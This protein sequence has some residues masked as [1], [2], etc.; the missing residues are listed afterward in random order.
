MQ[1]LV[2]Q[3]AA[4]P[5]DEGRSPFSRAGG[6]TKV[7]EKIFADGVTLRSDPAEPL[8]P[9][10]PFADDGLP[11]RPTTWAENGVLKKLWRSRYWAA[12][13]NAEP[14][15]RPRGL[16]LG[17]GSS[18][19]DELVAG[20]KRGLLVTRFWYIRMVDPQQLLLT[21]LTRDG[22]FLIEDGKVVAPV[23][24]FR[25]NESPIALLR[26][27]DG[28]G[29]VRAQRGSLHERLLVPAIRAHDFNFASGS[30]AI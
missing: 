16:H 19:A 25:F 10:T 7:S 14:D 24:N 28:L 21:G 2:N 9:T 18:T 5:A 26:N 20:V 22:L 6:G 12:R 8:A 4:R 29:R 11:L 13:T 15:G 1:W 23:R 27:T 17:A 3:L 30:D